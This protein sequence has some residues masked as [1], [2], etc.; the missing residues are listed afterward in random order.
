MPYSEFSGLDKYVSAT[1]VK[2]EHKAVCV[3]PPSCSH[4][5]TMD[6]CS[7]GSSPSHNSSNALNPEQ[8]P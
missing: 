5:V 3:P 4:R 7:Q 1:R 8:L 2:Q 6:E